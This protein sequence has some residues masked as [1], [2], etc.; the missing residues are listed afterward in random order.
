MIPNRKQR[1]A[2][3][4]ILRK[5]KGKKVSEFQTPGSEPVSSHAAPPA[6]MV[7]AWIKPQ[8]NQVMVE[9][10]E[11]VTQ[12]PIVGIDILEAA[13]L[14]VKE[15]ARNLAAA[16]LKKPPIIAADAGAINRIERLNG[17]R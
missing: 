4:S 9:M 14:I 10:T 1:R 11:I 5:L 7:K 17:G 8:S 16:N 12:N 15:H 3:E 2:Q 13:V 6:L